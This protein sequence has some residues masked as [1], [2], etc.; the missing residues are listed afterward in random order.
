M[1]RKEYLRNTLESLMKKIALLNTA[2]FSFNMGDYII[3]ESAKKQL[4]EILNNAFVVEIPTHSPMFHVRE[5]G[6]R[7]KNSFYDKLQSFD[8]KFVLGTNLLAHNMRYK[9]TTW[10]I[11]VI[12][13]KYFGD[14]VLLGVGTDPKDEKINMYTRKLYKQVLSS[15]YKHSVRDGRTKRML[16]DLGFD[17]INTGCSTMWGLNRAHCA[18]IPTSK[19]NTVIFTLTDYAKNYDADKKMIDILKQN[20]DRLYFWIQGFEDLEYLNQLCNRDNIEIIPPAIDDYSSFLDMHDCDFVGTRLHAAIKAMQKKKRS[21]IIG[22]DNRARDMAEDYGLHLIERTEIDCLENKIN[23]DFKTDIRI[24]E[25][26]IKEFL[27]QFK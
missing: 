4:M 7:R 20:Y 15:K 9:K 22:V 5:F 26:N 6:I 13:T 24:N 25:A 27:A 21:I 14:A 19:R 23:Q 10:N 18:E 2:I 17:A 1:G 8:Y 16:E 11:N 12:D 3:V